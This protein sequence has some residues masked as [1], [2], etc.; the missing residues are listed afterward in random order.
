M[1]KE[2][3]RIIAMVICSACLQLQQTF[4]P[5]PVNLPNYCKYLLHIVKRAAPG[6][7]VLV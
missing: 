1:T 2:H 4:A 3:D 5:L 6:Q 7:F